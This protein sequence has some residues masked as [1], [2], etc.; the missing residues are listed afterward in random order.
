MIRNVDITGGADEVVALLGANGAGKTTTLRVISGVVTPIAGR[1]SPEGD[2][3]A[4]LSPSAGFRL[5][6]AHVPEGRGIF[7]GLTVAE[8]F[9]LGHRGEQLDAELAYRYFP[10]LEELRHRRAGFLSGGEQ[11]MLANMSTSHWRWPTEA[12]SSPMARSSCTSPRRAPARPSSARRRLPGRAELSLRK[13]GN[14]ARGF[15]SRETPK[16]GRSAALARPLTSGRQLGCARRAP[17]PWR[18]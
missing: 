14:R 10:K 2:D 17:A 11:Q 6:I 4:S 18:I 5:G 7:Y 3:L 1:V 15:R 16:D 9:R 8:H 13:T 12:T